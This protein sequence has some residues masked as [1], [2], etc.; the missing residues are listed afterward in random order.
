MLGAC[1]PLGCGG[2]ENHALRSHITI[3]LIQHVHEGCLAETYIPVTPFN[4]GDHVA[5]QATGS[6]SLHIPTAISTNRAD[7]MPTSLSQVDESI[8]RQLPEELKVDL[9][10]LLP[11]HRSS[12]LNDPSSCFVKEP[13]HEGGIMIPE[14]NK[15]HLWAGNPP[16]WVKFKTS[17]CK[18][19]KILSETCQQ[20]GSGSLLSSCLQSLIS[21]AASLVPSD[22]TWHDEALSSW[23]EFLGQYIE[24]KV[25]SDMEELYLCFCI[26]KRFVLA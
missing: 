21:H 15:L 18:I 26:L 9:C 11:A 13:T 16:N 6:S 17:S 14:D 7:L 12:E 1:L 3:F 5:K 23:C 20:S 19:L 10:K 2:T 4:P 24:L 22:N 25:K 8:L